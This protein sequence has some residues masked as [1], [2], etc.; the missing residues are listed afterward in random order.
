MGCVF[1]GKIINTSAKKTTNCGG[2]VGSNDGTV[3]ISNCL[4]APAALASGETRVNDK[5]S[6]TF[7]RNQSGSSSTI[8]ITRCYYTKTFGEAQ[9]TKAYIYTPATA[10]FVPANVGDPIANGIYNTSGI[11]AYESGLKYNGKFYMEKVNV[12]LANNANNSAAIIDKQVADVK[13]KSRTLYKDG[14]WNT[15]CLP[16]DVTIASSPLAGDNVVAKVLDAS[17]ELADGTLT[18]NFNDAPATIPAGTP[19]IIKWDNTGVNLENPKFTDVTIDNTNRDVAFTGGTFK[20]NYSPLEIT[21]ANRNDILLLAAGNK[22]GYAK[23]DRTIANGKALGSCRAYFYIPSNNGGQGARAFELNFG[24]EETVSV[25][26]SEFIVHSKAG[27]I[28]DLQGRK[29]ENPKKGMYIIRGKKV[30]I[31]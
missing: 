12:F 20:G 29:V 1:D 17:S 14:D 10:S 8:T 22:L 5:N 7:V 23:T 11:T 2:F 16:F 25:H 31:K 26:S 28:Y 13:L 3:N 18:L 24:E 6:Y 27:A 19:F 21:D 30:V 9:G 4:Y 15:L